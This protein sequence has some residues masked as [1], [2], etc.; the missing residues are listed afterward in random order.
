MDVAV[1]ANERA[2]TGAVKLTSFLLS[3]RSLDLNDGAEPTVILAL[4]DFTVRTDTAALSKVKDNRVDTNII[5]MSHSFYWAVSILLI[6]DTRK[7]Q[8]NC[9]R[10]LDASYH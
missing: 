7:R 2:I 1:D 10:H 5:S 6:K 8:T 9:R 4:T 3:A